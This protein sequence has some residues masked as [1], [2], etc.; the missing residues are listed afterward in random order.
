MIKKV[1]KQ[2]RIKTARLEI[3][4]KHTYYVI[5]LNKQTKVV[6]DEY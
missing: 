6:N 1:W 3:E 4:F 5:I 2:V